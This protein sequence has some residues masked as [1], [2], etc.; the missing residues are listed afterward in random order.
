MTRPFTLFLRIFDTG[1]SSCKCCCPS[2]SE[3]GENN[4]SQRSFLKESR[5]F[6]GCK[7]F[8]GTLQYFLPKNLQWASGPAQPFVSSAPNIPSCDVYAHLTG[9]NRR[10]GLA[11]G[12]LLQRHENFP[13]STKAQQPEPSHGLKVVMA[14]LHKGFAAPI[15]FV[16]GD[17][18]KAVQFVSH[19]KPLSLGHRRGCICSFLEKRYKGP[20]P[21]PAEP[22][23]KAWVCVECTQ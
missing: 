8:C 20:A 11:M 2:T 6:Q 7:Y 19:Q 22:P 1:A 13:T 21:S 16:A 18:I 10:H 5:P 15:V 4:F 12:Q 9:S 23:T 14:P 3:A 17:A